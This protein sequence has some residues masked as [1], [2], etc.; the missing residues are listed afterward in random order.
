MAFLQLLGNQNND[1]FVIPNL[2]PVSQPSTRKNSDANVQ[3]LDALDK[4][5][6]INCMINQ[7]E[8]APRVRKGSIQLL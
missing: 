4:E 1:A 6:I 5:F 7:A 3:D 2:S 8:P